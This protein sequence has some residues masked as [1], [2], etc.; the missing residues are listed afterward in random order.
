MKKF[1]EKLKKL[2]VEVIKHPIG[3]THYLLKNQVESI[4]RK[5]D[6]EINWLHNLL[7]DRNEE[8]LQTVKL[9]NEAQPEIP[10]FVATEIEEKNRRFSNFHKTANIESYVKE[11]R[12]WYYEK[13]YHAELFY[14]AILDGYTVAKEKRFYL[15]HI[16]MSKRDVHHDYYAQIRN[17]R[18]EHDSVETG[19]LPQPVITGV[20]FTQQEIDSMETGSYEQIE[21]VK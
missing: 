3:D 21:V 11:V 15:K 12:D 14:R 17:E 18:F 2:N 6:K 20:T 10:E 8:V 5:A 16:E 7:D 9:L 4:V 1:E 13:P 19:T